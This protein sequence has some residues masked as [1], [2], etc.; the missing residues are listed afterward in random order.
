LTFSFVS[1]GGDF[2]TLVD[3]RA[4]GFKHSLLSVDV[5]VCMWVYCMSASLRLNSWETNGDSG[6]FLLGFGG[7]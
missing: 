3:M 1:G 4:A 7:V 2:L 6:I 5:A